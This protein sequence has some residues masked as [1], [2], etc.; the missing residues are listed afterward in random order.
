MTEN[1]ESD[2]RDGVIDPALV[3]ELEETPAEDPFLV[4]Y[5]TG[6]GGKS[7][8]SLKFIEKWFPDKDA[9]EGKTRIRAHQAHSLAAVRQITKVFDEVEHLEP[10]LE[11]MVNTYEQ[12]LTSIEGQSRQEHVE[13]L[14]TLFG[15][16]ETDKAESQSALMSAFAANLEQDED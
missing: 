14:R 10:F 11:D 3:E 8:E 12:Y 1:N 4:E 7:Q 5:M 9:W 16:P 15:G 6:S 13:I 2:E